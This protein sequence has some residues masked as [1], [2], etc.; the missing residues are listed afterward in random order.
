MLSEKF[1]PYIVIYRFEVIGT[2]D[3]SQHSEIQVSACLELD[4]RHRCKVKLS[5]QCCIKFGRKNMSL[6]QSIQLQGTEFFSV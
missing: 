1:Q 4:L 3:W 6:F 2:L 5:A